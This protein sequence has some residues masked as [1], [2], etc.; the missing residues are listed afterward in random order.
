MWET[1]VCIEPNKSP[2]LFNYVIHREIETP[3]QG[4]GGNLRTLELIISWDICDTKKGYVR[5]DTITK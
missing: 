4:S 1:Q 5:M 2:D 3:V